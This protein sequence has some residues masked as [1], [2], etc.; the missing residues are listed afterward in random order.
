[1]DGSDSEAKGGI[2][3]SMRDLTPLLEEFITFDGKCARCAN[4]SRFSGWCFTHSKTVNEGD[5]CDQF[6][7][8]RE[9]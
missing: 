4:R 6:R 2:R 1:M 8:R 3:I 9:K 5:T 7:Q